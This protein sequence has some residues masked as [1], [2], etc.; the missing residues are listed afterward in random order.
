M[1]I[2]AIDDTKS[3]RDLLAATLKQAG[4]DVVEAADGRE[5]LDQLAAHRPDAVISDLNMPNCDGIEFTRS[6]R[7][8]P[9]GA[10][11]PIVILTTEGD[12]A[13]KAEG[14][15]AGATAWMIKPFNPSVLLG[16]LDRFQAR[17]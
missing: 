12:P 13:I 15:K 14:R 3:L 10:G 5:G 17:A 16:L 8:R 1:R 4:H 7:Q 11:I 2:L 6:A 9:E